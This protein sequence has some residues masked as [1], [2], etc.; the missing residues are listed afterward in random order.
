MVVES[1]KEKE[2][3]EIRIGHG[4]TDVSCRHGSRWIW[5]PGPDGNGKWEKVVWACDCGCGDPPRPFKIQPDSHQS[6][7]PVK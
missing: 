7:L 4:M 2:I 3:Q 1:G 5:W 6:K